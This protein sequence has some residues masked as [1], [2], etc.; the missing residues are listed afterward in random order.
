VAELLADAIEVYPG[1][2]EYSL[3]EVGVG[4]RPC[5][6]DG[7]PIIE[8]ADDRTVIATGHGRNGIMLAPYTSD[9]VLELLGEAPRETGIGAGVTKGERV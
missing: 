6:P 3:T 5:S 9:A 1:L 8:R 7:L 2:R 4:F